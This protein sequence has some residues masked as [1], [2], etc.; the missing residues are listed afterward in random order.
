MSNRPSDG[1]LGTWLSPTVVVS[2]IGIALFL[3]MAL[4][5]APPVARRLRMRGL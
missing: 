5:V 4:L 1:V 2:M 3:V